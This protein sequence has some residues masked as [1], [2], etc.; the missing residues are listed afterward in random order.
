MGLIASF[1]FSPGSSIGLSLQFVWIQRPTSPGPRGFLW[2]PELG[3]S[4]CCWLV[5]KG[6]KAEEGA[7]VMWHKSCLCIDLGR[8]RLLSPDFV[9]LGISRSHS[10]PLFL[11]LE[12]GQ[13]IASEVR[14]IWLQ[15]YK[16]SLTCKSQDITITR[17]IQS[18]E[19][20]TAPW[21]LSPIS[22]GEFVR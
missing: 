20:P 9:I 13:Y 4:L 17:R 15:M 19:A 10:E 6:G 21:G 12:H 16:C 18:L 14:R 8:F 22:L 1:E 7:G 5:P 3:P 11:Q 2:C